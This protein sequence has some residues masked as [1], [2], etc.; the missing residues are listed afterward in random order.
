MGGNFRL[1]ALQAAILHIKLEYLASWAEA[2]RANADYYD[3]AFADRG[4]VNTGHITTPWR[5]PNATHVFNQYVIRTSQRDAL[6]SYLAER[7]VQTMI[8]Y[9]SPLH[10]QPCFASLGHKEGDFP[11]AER[12]CKEVLALPV[13][14]ELPREDHDYVIETI[15]SFFAEQGS[16][17]GAVSGVMNPTAADHLSGAERLIPPARLIGPFAQALTMRGLSSAGAL[18]DDA[19]EVIE[20]AGVIVRE[21]GSSRSACGAS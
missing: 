8:Y 14:P 9:P 4:I 15:A 2:R 5:H 7:G 16:T 12:A 13:Y 11:H 1:D 17:Q 6:K 10:L 20:Q 21:I 18:K 3:A 19:L